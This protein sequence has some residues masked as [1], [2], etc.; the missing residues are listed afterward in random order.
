MSTE[1]PI[2]RTLARLVI[3]AV[4]VPTVRLAAQSSNPVYVDSSPGAWEQLRLARE[5]AQKRAR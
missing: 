1:G 4:L 3:L 2:R 5:Q